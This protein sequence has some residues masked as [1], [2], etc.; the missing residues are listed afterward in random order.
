M[1]MRKRFDE[2]EEEVGVGDAMEDEGDEGEEVGL[3]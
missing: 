2:K 1:A 3:P